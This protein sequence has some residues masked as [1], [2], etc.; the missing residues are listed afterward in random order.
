MRIFLSIT[1]GISLIILA[2][3][4]IGYIFDG[5]TFGGGFI[6]VAAWAAVTVL[7]II[8]IEG[9]FTPEWAKNTGSEKL[10]KRLKECEKRLIDLQDIAIANDEKIKRLEQQTL[11]TPVSPQT[12]QD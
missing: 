7:A 1:I 10:S 5:P 2:G 11:V 6:L 9:T 12:I 4:T 3:G 8:I